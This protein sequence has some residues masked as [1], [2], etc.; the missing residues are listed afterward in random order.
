MR[1]RHPS[2]LPLLAIPYPYSLFPSFLLPFVLREDLEIRAVARADARL[3]IDVMHGVVHRD[4]GLAVSGGDQ[5]QLAGIVDDVARGVD[6]GEVRLHQL[7]H[8]DGV[9]LQL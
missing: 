9:A 4:R 5:L 2:P 8:L 3:G 1:S 7:R 6:A